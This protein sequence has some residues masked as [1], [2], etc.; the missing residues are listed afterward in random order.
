MNNPQLVFP[1]THYKE[2]YLAA[3]AEYKAAGSPP[4]HF[5]EPDG[6]FGEFV[7]KIK[8][9]AQGENLPAG[10]VPQTD[11]WLVDGE[12]YIGSLSIRHTLTDH[13]RE[14][15]GHIGY[16]IR[17][18]KRKMGY[19]KRILKLGLE[20]AKELGIEKVLLTCDVTN[21]GS[22]KI[23]E[24]NGGVLE[25]TVPNPGGPDKARFWIPT[26]GVQ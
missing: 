22:R 11:Y 3:V 23:I 13:L 4:Q 2:S 8:S 26:K 21:D 18:S 12:E 25:N 24:G 6:D 1:D 9:R 17:P 7:A 14:I 15:G 5:E 10:F 16:G 19:G 20:K